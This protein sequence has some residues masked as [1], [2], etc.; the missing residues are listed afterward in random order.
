MKRNGVRALILFLLISLC[1]SLLYGCKDNKKPFS[2]SREA[3][4]LQIGKNTVISI[5]DSTA[6]GSSYNA[7]WTSDNE[8]VAIVSNGLVTAIASGVTNI[9]AKLD[10]T[11][12]EQTYKQELVCTVTVVEDASAFAGLTLS[13]ESATMK[14]GDI[15]NVS[16]IFNPS[17]FENKSIKWY[18]SDDKVA[19]VTEGGVV[20]AA[21]IG[22]VV[23][24]AE[25]VDPNYKAQCII[26]VTDENGVGAE[27][28]LFNI[29][30]MYLSVGE[31]QTLKITVASSLNESDIKWKSSNSSVVTVSNDGTIKAKSQG[32][33]T[34][35]AVI[36]EYKA[37][38]V[39]SVS[40]SI[41]S[42]EVKPQDVTLS[43]DSLNLHVGQSYQLKKTVKPANAVYSGDWY[44][45]NRNVAS[46]SGSGNVTAN[47]VGTATITYKISSNIYA[48]CTV[49][50]TEK[51][52]EPPI[53]ETPEITLSSSSLKLNEGESGKL[54]ASLK[55]DIE[56][57]ELTFESSDKTV[58]SVSQDGTVTAL[59]EGTCTITVKNSTGEANKSCTVTVVKKESDEPE[60]PVVDPDNPD[61]PVKPDPEKPENPDENTDEKPDNGSENENPEQ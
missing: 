53:T 33:A 39:I 45:S 12:G 29:N 35:S 22:E 30:R 23:I 13:P 4:T 44:S 8:S 52:E 16:A 60:P 51:S 58:A 20:V 32:E 14:T 26:K 21:G 34:I 47:G 56:N 27:G 50:V 17:D 28:I 9:R 36:G 1:A 19:T 48:V 57:D 61:K 38:C 31:V 41:G 49:K 5:I 59:K 46:V 42:A 15:L 18:S 11:E 2:L 3:L 54:E 37:E 25:G 6:G 40:G 43:K 55:S 7:V 10:I 24:T